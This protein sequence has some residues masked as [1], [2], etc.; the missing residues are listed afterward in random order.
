MKN[1]QEDDSSMD[2]RTNS[3]VERV[4]TEVE[5]EVREQGRENIEREPESIWENIRSEIDKNN[6]IMLIT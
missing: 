5:T 3:I 2:E 6:D 4:R 1:L